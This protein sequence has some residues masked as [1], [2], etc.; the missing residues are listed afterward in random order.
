MRESSREKERERGRERQRLHPKATHVAP[1]SRAKPSR[2]GIVGAHAII[3]KRRPNARVI[4]E[5]Q[6]EMAKKRYL[7][8]KRVR[9]LWRRIYL[10]FDY[11]AIWYIFA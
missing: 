4:K 1:Q 11:N 8:P 6:L 10:L 3:I 2:A 7:K 5:T 9:Q